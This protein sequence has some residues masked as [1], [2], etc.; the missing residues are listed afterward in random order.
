MALVHLAV[1]DDRGTVSTGTVPTEARYLQ[2]H[3]SYRGSVP[4]DRG[5][6]PDDRVTVLNTHRRGNITEHTNSARQI[7]NLFPQIQERF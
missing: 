6:V 3:G 7:E 2:S 5:T 1:P 4:D